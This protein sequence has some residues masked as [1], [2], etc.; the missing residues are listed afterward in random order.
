MNYYKRAIAI[1]NGMTPEQALNLVHKIAEDKPSWIV[2]AVDGK[3]E[4]S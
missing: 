2:R 3:R 4:P 1:L